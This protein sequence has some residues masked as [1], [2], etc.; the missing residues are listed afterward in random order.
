MKIGIDARFIG[1]Q[2]T[3]LGKYTEKLIENL[4]NIDSKNQYVIFLRRNN[5][6]YL[7]LGKNFSKV[8]A[9]IPWYS[10]KEQFKMP[11]IFQESNLDFLHVPHFN[12]PIFY[13]GKFIVTIHDLI[14]HQFSQESATTRNFLIFKGKRIAY[15][16][17][18]SQAVKKSSKII[19]PS[20]ATKQEIL[21]TFNINPKKIVVTYEAAEE[22]YFSRQPSAISRQK[23][24]KKYHIKTPFIIYVGNA[25]PHKNLQTLL[26]A[27][28]LLN[29]DQPLS[30][31]NLVIVCARDVFWQRLKKQIDDQKLQSRVIMTDYIAANDLSKIFREAESYV[32]PSLAEGFGIPGLDAMA[33]G[34]PVVCSNIPT[35][36]EVYGDAA[37]YFDPE[38]PNDIASKIKLA[39]SDRALRS[40]LIDS[41]FQQVK[42]YSWL[43]MAKETLEVYKRIKTN[44]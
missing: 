6:D 35:L 31:I 36:K 20:Q 14:H 44:K 33:S 40:K 39:I 7:K 30:R 22:E 15:K 32:F 10:L 2:G 23:L 19:C 29:K 41:S 1:P 24:L 38:S 42:K 4:S 17:I 11:A 37:L 43:K 18:I 12:V 16:I 13:K 28:N 9:D 5:W 21:E 34:L 26:S 25:Y 8:L 3:G 27:M